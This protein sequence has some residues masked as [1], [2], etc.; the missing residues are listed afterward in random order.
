MAPSGAG[1]GISS[2]TG[3]VIKIK[4]YQIPFLYNNKYIIKGC[5]VRV[6]RAD[7]NIWIWNRLGKDLGQHSSAESVDPDSGGIFE[8]EFPEERDL[9][10]PGLSGRTF[11]GEDFRANKSQT[12]SFTL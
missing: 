7:K 4:G 9:Y 12:F 10:N 8:S 5:M 6:T 1:S 3:E 11:L 2:P